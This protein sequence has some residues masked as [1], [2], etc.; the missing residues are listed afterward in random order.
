[1]QQEH[2]DV[3]A[4]EEHRDREPMCGG[5]FQSH[6]GRQVRLHRGNGYVQVFLE[7]TGPIGRWLARG[8]PEYQEVASSLGPFTKDTTEGGG[9]DFYFIKVLSVSIAGGDTLWR[10]D[11][12]VV[13]VNDQ[14]VG[15]SPCGFP[16]PG[17]SQD[18]M[19][20]VLCHEMEWM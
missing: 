17:Y 10:E 2:T 20:T 3:V 14:N 12:V 5:D 1:M 6:G 7:S 13:G 9:R 19:P 11:L 4:E 15:G 18:N 16:L 8:P